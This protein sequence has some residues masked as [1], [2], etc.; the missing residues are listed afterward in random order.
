MVRWFRAMTPDCVLKPETTDKHGRGQYAMDRVEEKWSDI[1]GRCEHF[2]TDKGKGF[3]YLA[4][5]CSLL[6]RT[7]KEIDSQFAR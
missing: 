2:T 5:R 3:P 4:R 1:P 7:L 6:C